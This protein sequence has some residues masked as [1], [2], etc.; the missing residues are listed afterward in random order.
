LALLSS[1]L[2]CRAWQ[3]NNTHAWTVRSLSRHTV[4]ALLNAGQPD[5]NYP[6]SKFEVI[7]LFQVYNDGTDDMSPRKARLDLR[8]RFKDLN[9][10]VWPA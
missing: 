6:K 8:E 5:N 2:G 4:A 10:A 9:D 7:K 3:A 1:R